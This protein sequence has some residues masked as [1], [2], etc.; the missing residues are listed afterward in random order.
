VITSIKVAASEN[1]SG[2][3]EEKEK[4]SKFQGFKVSRECRGCVRRGNSET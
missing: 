1:A 3:R 4:V 2:E